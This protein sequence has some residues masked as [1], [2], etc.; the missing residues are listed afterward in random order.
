MK[1]LK[2]WRLSRKD[3]S[4]K[5]SPQPTSQP[6]LP[7]LSIYRSIS[8]LPLHRFIDVLVDDNLLAL[9]ITGQNPDPDELQQAWQTILH[10]Y[11]EALGSSEYKVY[12]SL[13]KEVEILKNEYRLIHTLVDT[14]R[15]IQEHLILTYYNVPADVLEYQKKCGNTLNS[16]L[17]I[18]CTF[19]NLDTTTYEAELKKCI[20]RSSALKIR[21]DLKLI[22]FEAISKKQTEGKK[23]DRA[24]FDSM[25]ITI[26]DHAK[27]EISENITVAKYCER[28]KR[29]EKYC[30]SLNDR[31]R[32]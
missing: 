18:S 28:V 16:L 11:A 31:K 10:E 26:S 14:M 13:Y 27:Y 1:K 15:T 32:G 6:E 23:A 8:N 17:R 25:L 24:Y 7:P 5:S 29:Y 4:T 21:L 20:R 22:A 2:Q 19:N 9:V 30:Q 12:L 3:V